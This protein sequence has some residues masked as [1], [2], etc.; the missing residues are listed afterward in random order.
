MTMSVSTLGRHIIS[1]ALQEVAKDANA[2]NTTYEFK[3]N[4][5]RYHITVNDKNEAV[6]ASL[7]SRPDSLWGKI[8]SAVCDFFGISTNKRLTDAF[9]S[10]SDTQKEIAMGRNIN[11][12]QQGA[13]LSNPQKIGGLPEMYIE[14]KKIESG[15]HNYKQTKFTYVNG[16]LTSKDMIKANNIAGI[17][18]QQT[19]DDQGKMK[20]SMS[21]SPSVYGGNKGVIDKLKQVDE[22]INKKVKK[23]EFDLSSVSSNVNSTT[24]GFGLINIKGD[25][26]KVNY[27]LECVYE[28]TGVDLRNVKPQPDSLVP[29]E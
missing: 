19:L 29:F 2:T 3:L 15:K 14:R 27:F 12:P 23:E 8:K 6:S 5:K 21:I 17:S 10:L 26:V 24:I 20:W 11:E 9:N 16:N 4:N 18:I 7:I 1:N 28:E 25:A 22:Y 13:I